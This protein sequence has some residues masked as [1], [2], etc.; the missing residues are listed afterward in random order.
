MTDVDIA[1]VSFGQSNTVS[2]IQY[3]TALNAIANGGKLVT[4][5]IM[6]EVVHYDN[7][8]K[9]IYDQK[10]DNYNEK[11]I[12]KEDVANTLR[13]YLEKVV[14]EGGGKKANIPGYHIAGKTGTAQKVDSITKTYAAGK[15]VASFGGM[16]PADNP[17]VTLFVSIDEPDPSNYYAGQMRSCCKTSV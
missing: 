1:T 15:Y 12:L 16:A 6:K 8:N 17:L 10:Y 11:S 13:G 2:S 5:H 3:L 7:S 9:K 4:P 14:G